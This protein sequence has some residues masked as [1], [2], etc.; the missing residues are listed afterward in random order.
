MYVALLIIG[1]I[2]GV[3]LAATIGLFYV[4]SLDGEFQ[5]NL[6]ATA[7]ALRDRVTGRRRYSPAPG[8]ERRA[9][10]DPRLRSMQE[11]LRL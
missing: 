7:V 8:V 6:R 5:A 10:P 2:F 9:D 4:I 3:A 1:V 11:E